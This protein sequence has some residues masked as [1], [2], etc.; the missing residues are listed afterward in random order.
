MVLIPFNTPS[1]KN[2]K[3]KT[4]KGIFH[5]KTVQKYLRNLGIKSYSCSKKTYEL[6]KTIPLKFPLSELQEQFKDVE[7]PIIVELHFVRDS[8]RAF[9]FHNLSQI[10][11]DLLQAF[12]IIK[13]DDMNHIIPF[14]MKI[15]NEWY[16][17]DKN[18]SGVYIN[19]KK[20]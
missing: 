10:I 2:S 9:D 14:P 17:I 11:F 4:S 3:I 20:E 7:Y 12:A 5:S 18:K 1:S 16:S 15:N 8:K 19:I 6:Y 13:D